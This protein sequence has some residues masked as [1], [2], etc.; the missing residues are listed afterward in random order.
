MKLRFGR[1]ELDPAARE[2]R[3]D[4]EPVALAAKP[5]ALL[6]HLMAQRHRWVPKAEL[7][8]RVWPD[9]VVSDVALASVLHDLREA[10]GDD[11][12]AQAVVATR[13]RFGYRFVADAEEREAARGSAAADPIA[14]SPFVGRAAVLARIEAAFDRA[15][16]GRGQLVLL[17]G[18]AGIGKTR[19]AEEFAATARARGVPV[20]SGWC[21][22]TGGA[23]AYWPWLQVLRA[24][25]EPH[26]TVWIRRTLGARARRIAQLLPE[27]RERLPGVEDPPACESPDE[28]RFR[29][30]DAVT[31]LL[32]ETAR[33]QALVVVLDDLHAGDAA[34]LG[35]LAFVAR[36]IGRAQLLVLGTYRDAEV[37]RGH[38][39][40]EVLARAARSDDAASIALEGL[41]RDDV[42]ALL[43]ALVGEDPPDELVAH[44]EEQ[45][46]G[47]PFLIRE[48]A[49]SLARCGRE[50]APAGVRAVVRD[51]MQQMS[52]SAAEALQMAAVIGRDFGAE[53]L[54]RALRRAPDEVD[55]ALDEARRAGLLTD[56]LDARPRYAHVLLRD[57]VYEEQGATARAERHRAVAHALETLR[58]GDPNARL[59]ELAHHFAAAA[60]LGVADRAA[61]Y[62]ARAAERAT[63][64]Y[65]YEEAAAHYERALAMLDLV[66]G[67]DPGSRCDLL[68]ALGAVSRFLSDPDSYRAA[69]QRALDLARATNDGPRMGRAAFGLTASTRVGVVDAE[70]ARAI[71]AALAHPALAR[72]A[73]TRLLL[74]ARLA[75]LV[76][77]DGERPRATALLAEACALAE[78]IDDA[79]TLA[80]FQGIRA[81]ILAP[82]GASPAEILA[83][84]RDALR[85][86]ER[87]G[88]RVYVLAL[89]MAIAGNLIEL[90]E[91]EELGRVV[92]SLR[93]DSRANPN[94]AFEVDQYR[95]L[96]A[97]ACGRLAEAE[98]LVAEAREHPRS[99]SL[100]LLA[101]AQLYVLRWEQ[102]RLEE[103]APGMLGDAAL[104][105][106]PILHAWRAHL[107]AELGRVEQA[108]REIAQIGLENAAGESRFAAVLFGAPVADALARL[109]DAGPAAALLERL[110]PYAH[111]N[112]VLGNLSA[113][114]G[115]VARAMGLLTMLLGRFDEADAWFA[116]AVERSASMGWVV[117]ETRARI[118]RASMRLARGAPGDGQAARA[119]VATALDTTRAL[120]LAGLARRAELVRAQLRN[121]GRLRS[122]RPGRAHRVEGI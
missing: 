16:V 19:T 88:D 9:V 57:A 27:L 53:L 44:A 12:R 116:E 90:G 48:L 120:G 106:D 92:A 1:F 118:D 81:M 2:L 24:L 85:H 113:T 23:P 20:L 10:L 3:R 43:R 42:R 41:A 21:S 34:S 17:A 99:S 25:L 102:D 67:A 69:Y 35:L 108:R 109:G 80:R 119:D 56:S 58:G 101:Q 51:R 93:A 46:D 7:L 122:P 30:R 31:S 103:L 110:G 55:A 36:E 86:A 6:L 63:S 71:E 4:G 112:V 68:L 79:R 37:G 8:D 74:L 105:G 66:P 15:R 89:E 11:G 100:A 84:R 76:L 39:L 64:L 40:G 26:G 54:A 95:G 70:A 52:P 22:E 18:E 107:A 45:T 82:L 32:R 114:L 77:A 13:K 59:A 61:H 91:R 73:A 96:E 50:L 78:R 38:P 14:S 49:A 111:S 87:G 62:A 117:W 121:P 28:A 83:V 29:L 60:A 97:L 72:D 75:Q 98:Q 104:R 47:N 115:P 65:A 94:V 33:E 5:L